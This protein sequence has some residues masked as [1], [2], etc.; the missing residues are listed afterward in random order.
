MPPQ[1]KLFKNKNVKFVY[2][3]L[4]WVSRQWIISKVNDGEGQKN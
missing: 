1:Q 3:A 2:V 4:M